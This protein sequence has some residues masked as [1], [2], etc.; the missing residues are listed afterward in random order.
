MVPF[1]SDEPMRDWLTY[2]KNQKGLLSDVREWA[3]M[4]D[5]PPDGAPIAYLGIGRD[6]APHTNFASLF[7]ITFTMRNG[8]YHKRHWT[9]V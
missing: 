7:M 5:L 2:D 1:V 9:A 4:A 3:S 8:V 6:A